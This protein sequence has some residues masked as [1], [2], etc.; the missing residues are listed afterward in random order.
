MRYANSSLGLFGPLAL[1]LSGIAVPAQAAPG[2]EAHDWMRGS[3]ML[4]VSVGNVVGCGGSDRWRARYSGAAGKE[5]SGAD[6]RDV[7]EFYDRSV[8]DSIATKRARNC[9]RIRSSDVNMAERE[10]AKFERMAV[11]TNVPCQM[12]PGLGCVPG[13]GPAATASKTKQPS[14]NI[15]GLPNVS[16]GAGTIKLPGGI[17]VTLPGAPSITIPGTDGH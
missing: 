16:K 2:K 7:M 3:K 8:A 12:R 4:V 5:L 11:G 6:Y 1:V 15:N 9:A 17:G 10:T 13:T 14:V